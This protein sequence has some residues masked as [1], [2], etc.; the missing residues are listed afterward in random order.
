[1][2]LLV[3]SVQ[4]APKVFQESLEEGAALEPDFHT[5]HYFASE[6]FCSFV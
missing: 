5:G 1:M 3:L 2:R 6:S 4:S